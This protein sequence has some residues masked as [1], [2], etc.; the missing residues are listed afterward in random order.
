MFS[1][2]KNTIIHRSSRKTWNG[3]H[4]IFERAIPELLENS[5]QSLR[6]RRAALRIDGLEGSLKSIVFR[7]K[8]G[9][10]KGINPEIE[11]TVE[12]IIMDGTCSLFAKLKETLSTRV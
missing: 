2:S 10:I 12:E 11:R 5:L 3:L 4:K 1:R 7:K 9:Y 6:Y 8:L